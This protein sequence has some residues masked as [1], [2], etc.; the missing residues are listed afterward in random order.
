NVHAQLL[1]DNNTRLWVFSP[2]TLTCADPPAMIGYCDQ[3]QG[4]NRTFYAH[5][6]SLGGRNGHFDFPVGGQHDWGNWGPQLAAMADDV[7]AAIR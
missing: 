5:Y 6:R 7:A 1:V 3:A 2:Q 4:S